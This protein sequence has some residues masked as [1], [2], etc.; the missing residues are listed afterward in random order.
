MSL[1][2][3]IIPNVYGRAKR[4]K[5]SSSRETEN[6]T[7]TA[8]EELVKLFPV[9]SFEGRL[10]PIIMNHQL[11]SLVKNKTKCDKELGILREEKKV[12]LFKMGNEADEFAILFTETYCEYVLKL[13][14]SPVVENFIEKVVKNSSE[15]SFNKEILEKFSIHE[16]EVKQLI[17]SGVMTLRDVG[18]WWL[19]IP[20]AGEYVT[21]FIKGRRHLLQ[22]VKKCKYGEILYN[23]LI[24]RKM[25]KDAKLGMMYH[26]HDIIGAELIK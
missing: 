14:T 5:A 4:L 11:Y 1:K 26:I 19:A 7:K 20:G 18:S 3:P 12:K 21:T 8:L 24:Q 25:R 6:E 13:N 15:V 9:E 17:K 23:D 2:R 22:M 16:E 10:P